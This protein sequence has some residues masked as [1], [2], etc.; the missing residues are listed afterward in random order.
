MLLLMRCGGGGWMMWM[1]DAGGKVEEGGDG[2]R[3]LIP[4]CGRSAD[5]AR[6]TDL[7]GSKVGHT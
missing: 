6:V 3:A 5:L 1:N 2:G 7:A 4:V